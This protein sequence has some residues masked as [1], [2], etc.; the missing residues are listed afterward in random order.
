MLPSTMPETSRRITF[1][2]VE[3]HTSQGGGTLVTA[4]ASSLLAFRRLAASQTLDLLSLVARSL[5]PWRP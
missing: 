4:C 1:T 5:P 2:R 3:E